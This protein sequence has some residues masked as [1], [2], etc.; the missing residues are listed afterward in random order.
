MGGE[1]SYAS[2]DIEYKPGLQVD[3]NTHIY[4]DSDLYMVCNDG[5]LG[6]DFIEDDNK[7]ISG[8]VYL[9]HLQKIAKINIEK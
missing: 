1:F 4:T 7:I 6:E 8:D 5:I 3:K 2:S 9:V